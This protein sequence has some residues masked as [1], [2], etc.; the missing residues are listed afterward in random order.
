MTSSDYYDKYF[1]VA[2]KI[3]CYLY[4][5]LEP[6]LHEFRSC[7]SLRGSLEGGSVHS[8]HSGVLYDTSE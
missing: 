5:V 2:K 8:V 4:D 6:C 7:D 3:L 1:D